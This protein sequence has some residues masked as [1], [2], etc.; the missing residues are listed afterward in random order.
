PLVVHRVAGGVRRQGAGVPA[1]AG[2]DRRAG[3]RVAVRAGGSLP[4]R[5]AGGAVGAAA[6]SGRA[7]EVTLAVHNDHLALVITA[8][9]V[10]TAGAV[11]ASVRL[12]RRRRAPVLLAFPAAAA[13]AAWAAAL[14]AAVTHESMQDA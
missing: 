2:R 13:M 8:A 1:H 4:R 7:S 11:A 12:I 10:V 5:P 9:F 3:G 14:L 6:P